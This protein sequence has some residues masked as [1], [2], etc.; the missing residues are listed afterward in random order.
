MFPIEAKGSKRL[1]GLC[2][3]LGGRKYLTVYSSRKYLDEELF[4][5]N[6]IQVIYYKYA[7]P[8]YPQLW[9][10]FIANLSTFDLLFTC[11]PK[12]AGIIRQCGRLIAS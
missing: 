1:V 4:R 6:G 2:Q 7:S 8:I 3:V 12:S 11:G 5:R 9:G 10:D